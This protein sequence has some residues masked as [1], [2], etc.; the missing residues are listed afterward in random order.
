MGLPLE[1]S[2]KLELLK[3]DDERAKHV[4]WHSSAHVLG[5][6]LEAVY[7]GHL[8]IGPALK[9]GGFY[10]DMFIGNQKIGE[11]DLAEGG[12]LHKKFEEV[13][14]AQQKFEKLY[15]TK[16]QALELFA[17]NPFKVSLS[18]AEHVLAAVFASTVSA[19]ALGGIC[20]VCLVRQLC[21]VPNRTRYSLSAQ[22][23]SINPTLR[24]TSNL[25]QHKV[26]KDRKPEETRQVKQSKLS[27]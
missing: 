2:C 20:T 8:T 19:L 7:G 6:A 4:F 1:Y 24:P 25:Q 10:Y 9:N 15:I 14:K 21:L 22:E 26:I 18:C 23:H 16:E 17:D 11:A 13:V 5:Q 12:K 27:A 3:F